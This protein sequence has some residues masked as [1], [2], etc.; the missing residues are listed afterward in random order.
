[1]FSGCGARNHHAERDT[2]GTRCGLASL[3]DQQ[4]FQSPRVPIPL[5]Y[6]IAVNH[7]SKLVAIPP[8]SKVRHAWPLGMDHFALD[9]VQATWNSPHFGTRMKWI[10]IASK[11]SPSVTTVI[12]TP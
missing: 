2:I 9:V 12:Y 3:C 5:G 1:M 8:N 11:P 6:A 4:I 10:D 7:F